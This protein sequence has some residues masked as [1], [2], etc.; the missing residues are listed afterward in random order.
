MPSA[1]EKKTAP[2]EIT[3]SKRGINETHQSNNQ[4]L[5]A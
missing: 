3:N 1:M 2:Q 5:Q 4:T